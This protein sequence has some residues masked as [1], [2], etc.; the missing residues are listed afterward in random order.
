LSRDLRPC[1]C[2]GDR[3]HTVHVRLPWAQRPRPR[4]ES[5]GRPARSEGTVGASCLMS[6]TSPPA[7]PRHSG[8]T[9][10]AGSDR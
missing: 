7:R 10:P 4:R 6:A 2:S 1:P 5:G 8:R 9:G 3:A